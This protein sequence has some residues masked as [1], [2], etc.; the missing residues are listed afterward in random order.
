MDLTNLTALL[1]PSL[2]TLFYQI[3]NKGDDCNHNKYKKEDFCDLGCPCSDAAKPEEGSDQGDDEE[4][5]GV[6]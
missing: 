1:S 5:D 6:T 4:D 3:Y 2:S